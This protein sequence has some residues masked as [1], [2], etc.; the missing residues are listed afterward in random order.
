MS[1]FSHEGQSGDGSRDPQMPLPGVYPMKFDRDSVV[2]L[3]D[4]MESVI[5]NG[6][7]VMARPHLKWVLNQYTLL[8]SRLAQSWRRVVYLPS[9]NAAFWDL[10]ERDRFDWVRRRLM[11]SARSLDI[12]VLDS[13]SL[14]EGLRPYR[15]PDCPRRTAWVAIVILDPAGTGAMWLM[16]CSRLRGTSVCPTIFGSVWSQSHRFT[17]R[18]T[19]KPRTHW[20][21]QWWR[22]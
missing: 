18:R 5:E 4:S 17:S 22:Y 19:P 13:P 6:D 15:D 1:L 2:V 12:L 16:S 8:F 20:A 11:T 14:W 9:P 3:M 21:S 10:V 7:R